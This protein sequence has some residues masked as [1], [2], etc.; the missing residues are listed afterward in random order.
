MTVSHV[1]KIGNPVPRGR[2]VY[3]LTSEGYLRQVAPSG[4]QSTG[5][6]SSRSHGYV[7]K[8]SWSGKGKPFL[9]VCVGVYED[10]SWPLGQAHRRYAFPGSEILYDRSV[11]VTRP[12]ASLMQ[13][14]SQHNE[15]VV[16]D[17]LDSAAALG[18]QENN[19]ACLVKSGRRGARIAALWN[20]HGAAQAVASVGQ[21]AEDGFFCQYY[22]YVLSEAGVEE[23]SNK[24]LFDAY[25][26]QMVRRSTAREGLYGTPREF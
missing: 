20:L 12:T 9:P 4:G 17:I 23:I 21:Q 25:S 3:R 26:Y 2:S 5:A 10:T 16:G 7:T 19:E 6:S 1:E 15:V 13:V 24:E 8:A 18:T 14:G 11:S 22:M